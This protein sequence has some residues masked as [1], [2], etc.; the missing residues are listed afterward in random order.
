M[1]KKTSKLGQV[2]SLNASTMPEDYNTD[3]NGVW[4][5]ELA[6]WMQA[7]TL[8][9]LFFSEDWVYI[10][11]DLIAR[12]ISNIPRGVMRKVKDSD[13]TD[14]LEPVPEHPLN[15]LLQNPNQ[16]QDEVSFRYVEAVEHTLMGNAVLW[17]S[18]SINQLMLLP[19]ELVYLEFDNQVDKIKW[20]VY[21]SAGRETGGLGHL[22]L[23][24]ADIMHI[25]RPNPSSMLWGLSPFI[26]GRQSVLFNRY[27]AEYMNNFYI[28][29]AT[30]SIALVMEKDA[31]VE[32][33]NRML[34]TFEAAHTGRRNQR[35][36]MLMP[37]GVD[38]RNVGSSIADQELIDLVKQ[39]RETI[40]ALLHVPKHAVGLAESG[41]LG[42]EEHK[43]ALKYL[44]TS[45]IVPID[46]QI[47]AAYSKFFKWSLGD[48]LVVAS[49]LSGVAILQEDEAKKAE[50]GQKLLSTHTVNEV[51]ATLYGL[52][53]IP[54]G[55]VVLELARL[56]KANAPM[57]PTLP[58]SSSTPPEPP[59]AEEQALPQGDSKATTEGAPSRYRD[60]DF[61]PPRPVAAAA[62][63]GLK[64][65]E[66]YGR[67]GTA[68]GVARANQLAKREGISPET[69]RRGYRFFLRHQRNM[70]NTLED[71]AP[72]NGKIASHL[73]GHRAGA[74]WF[75]KLWDAMEAADKQAGE[76]WNDEGIQKETEEEY[77]DL[78]SHGSHAGNDFAKTL[79]EKYSLDTVLSQQDQAESDAFPAMHQLSLDTFGQMFDASVDVVVSELTRGKKDFDP[80]DDL[81]GLVPVSVSSARLQKRLDDAF[82]ELSK[83]WKEGSTKTLT[84]TVDAGYD[85]QLG[86]A[87]MAPAREEVEALKAENA[88]KRLLI[89]ESRGLRTF[90]DV[91]G[92]TTKRIVKVVER[93]VEQGKSIMEITRDIADDFKQ[94]SPARAETIA[95][96]ETLTA[97]SMGQQAMLQDAMSVKGPDG[98]PVLD[99]V[100]VWMNAGD[101]RVRGRPDGMYPDAK[102]NH[103]DVQGDVANHD[104]PFENGLEF[105]R[106]PKGEAGNVINCRCSLITVP[107]EDV[108][109]LR[110]PKE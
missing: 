14:K 9:G 8:K 94:I 101:L 87:F 25:R 88:S 55:D 52:P 99:L 41:S 65:R 63:K 62:E 44:W 98:K 86:L 104:E 96:T 43:Q 10:V 83:E 92:T 70:D 6:A 90:K 7:S 29:G 77:G 45:T 51:R 17:H 72:A 28:K 53:P 102:F 39:N 24:P 61:T 2:K 71:G 22:R 42:S 93:G 40:I 100:K 73:W 26:P 95:R 46:A 5:P 49:D 91:S 3:S 60:I 109:K 59:P 1:R 20:Y 84:A 67:G 58:P 107:R 75:K 31:N 80:P 103:W 47:N 79:V 108:A 97:Y 35:R 15:A 66:E 19:T 12:E 110:I 11:V 106:D 105:P 74:A 82:E 32:S 64:W 33:V 30:P 76:K 50:H 68:V 36:T 18:R 4:T 13:G 34:K 69:A 16:Y 27:S 56:S 54:G 85:S 89:L 23:S 78:D 37:K 81:P 38:I 21:M 57:L 48:Q